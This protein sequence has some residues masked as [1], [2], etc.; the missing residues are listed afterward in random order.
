MVVESWEGKVAVIGYQDPGVDDKQSK[1]HLVGNTSPHRAPSPHPTL[2]I[3]F[4]VRRFP[5][6]TK[7]SRFNYLLLSLM[8]EIPQTTVQPM[9]A[10]ELRV[11]SCTSWERP[12]ALASSEFPSACPK[13][14]CT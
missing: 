8:K 2:N 1:T 12:S 6:E 3:D 14:L 13:Y 10:K 4:P 9:S 11:L 7:R 5:A